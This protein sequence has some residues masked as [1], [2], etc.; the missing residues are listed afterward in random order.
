MPPKSKR[1]TPTSPT[2]G[3][4]KEFTSAIPAELTPPDPESPRGRIL[5]AARQIFAEHGFEGASTRALAE[6]AGVNLA[7]IHYYFGSKEQ[8]YERV[9]ASEIIAMFQA[10]I[11]EV[12]E[13]LP[14]EQALLSMPI[15]IMNVLRANPLRAALFRREIASGATHFAR[16][17]HGLGEHGPIRLAQIFQQLYEGAVHTGKLRD[18]PA[19]SVR[20]YLLSIAFSSLYMGPV[21]SVISG[22]GLDTEAAWQEWMK[23]LN[24][25]L[26][27][28]LLVESNT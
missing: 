11:R 3:I 16:A 10:V 7:M 9:L 1:E 8:L 19:D 25:L 23:T 28:G 21:M 22:R 27:Q 5:E 20:E 12:P 15:R 2:S 13:N 14:P 4:L 17:I 18:L 26:R 24:T 6:G